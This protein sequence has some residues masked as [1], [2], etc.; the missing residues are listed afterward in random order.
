MLRNK[1][2][3]R[4]LAI[5][6]LIAFVGVSVIMAVPQLGNATS[7]SEAQRKQ[8]EAQAGKQAAESKR[9]D[10]LV[11]R[12]EIDKQITAVQNEINEYQRQIDEKA[13]MITKSEQEITKLSYELKSQ[14]ASYNAR[15]K[16]LIKKG[17]ASYTEIILNSKS[18]DDF[19]T[20]SS[21]LKRVA[22]YD[23]ERMAE[24]EDSMEEVEVLKDNLLVQKQEVIDLKAQQDAKKVELDGYRAESQRIIDDLQGQIEE[25][26][27]QYELAKQAEAA[28][29][30]EIARLIQ[31]EQSNQ[32]SSSAGASTTPK[33]VPSSGG[34]FQW[35]STTTRLVTSPYGYRIHPVTGKSRFHSGIDIGAAYGTDIVAAESG[36]VIVSGYNTGGYGNYVVISHG[37]GYS[38]LYA[39]C[40]SLLVSRGQQVSRGQV[41][42]KCGSTGMSTG[43]HI[44][45]EVQ[46]NGKTTDPLSY[47]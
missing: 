15:A 21:V 24:I 27:E 8:K 4:V 42:A 46:V 33:I 5:L 44:H 31:Q 26:E 22:K 32:S 1:N 28:A 11:R 39:H 37:G 13:A 14:N 7:V 47:Y 29:R 9:S 2:F 43:P 40:S 23:S 38:T 41:I 34:K 35:P 10:E 16:N 17:D 18:I 3:I 30:A 36:T 6:A 12:D 45:Y 20:R 19:L 25:F